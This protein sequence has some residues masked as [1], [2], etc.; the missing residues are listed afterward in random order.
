MRIHLIGVPSAGKSTLG[1]A[2][3]KHLGFPHYALDELVFVDDRWTLRPTS[4]R[5]A[6]LDEILAKPSFITEGGFLGWTDDLFA[7]SDLILWL[8]PPL[9]VLVWRH[10]RRFARRPWWIPSL[11]RFQIQSYRRPAGTGPAK[12]DPN[13][14]RAG[15]MAALK[16]WGAKVFRVQ[17]GVDAS[18]IV[19]FLNRREQ[20]SVEDTRV[21]ARVGYAEDG[22]ELRFRNGLWP[23]PSSV[24][25]TIPSQAALSLECHR[26]RRLVLAACTSRPGGSCRTRV[27]R[28]GATP[29]GLGDGR[30][31]KATLTAATLVRRVR[32][33]ATV[34]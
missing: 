20:H 33:G 19:A 22:P 12:D 28:L 23:I 14:T 18:E 4:E 21:M 24:R 31:V 32:A 5:N 10:V 17:R 1:K 6:M 29:P 26:P 16:P 13:Q 34:A 30:S 27:C 9:R 11:V 8:D 7:E 2:L 25:P 15:I 3:S